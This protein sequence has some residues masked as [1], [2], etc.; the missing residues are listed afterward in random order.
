ME[1]L[2]KR[3]GVHCGRQMQFSVIRLSDDDDG[4]SIL[5]KLMDGTLITPHDQWKAQINENTELAESAYSD[6]PITN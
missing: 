6:D 5:Y 4:E 1:C 3:N 2:W